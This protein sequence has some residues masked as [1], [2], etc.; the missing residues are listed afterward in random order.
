M[1]FNSLVFLLFFAVV[2]GCAVILRPRAQNL[3][4]LAASYFFYG[5][6]DWRFLGLLGVSTTL[7]FLCGLRIHSA[8]GRARQVWLGVSLAGNL[9]LLFFF[10]YFN[11]FADSAA[12]ALRAFGMEPGWTTLHIVLPVGISFYTFQTLSY[13]IDI[14]RG[15]LT[16]TRSPVIFALYVAFFPQ[17]VA[18]PIERAAHLL[19]Q[20]ANPRRPT[21]TQLRDGFW[22]ILHGYLLKVVLSDNLAPFVDE[23]FTAPGEAHG[24]QIPAAVLAFAFQ[25]YGDF[26]GYSNIARG[27]SF[28]L[29]VDL[30][31]NFRQPYFATNPSDFW[32]RWHIS[33]STWLRD[34]LYIPLGGNRAGARRTQVNLLLT[35]VLG[36]LW[37]GAAWNFVAWGLYHGLLL[38]AYHALAPWAAR[39]LPGAWRGQLLGAALFFPFTLFGWLLFRVENLG[40]VVTLMGNTVQ[41]FT[42]NGKLSLLTL[43]G[44]ALPVLA[45]DLWQEAKGDDRAVARLPG[46]VRGTLYLL[47][48]ALIILCGARG[49]HVFI[50]FQF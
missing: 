8:Q 50:Y 13:T 32:R 30:M 23:V 35:M 4:L 40:D 42:W 34:Y 46:P 2:F 12:A 39:A 41:P 43:A 28:W 7:D 25:I 18:G 5:Y 14:Y 45:V 29:G 33:L 26:A 36:G 15:R 49:G 20:L 3:F 1:V 17:L 47:W 10:K 48:F 21:Y 44:F 38:V 27:I 19:P 6:W 31:V 24:L 22:L 16:P 9:G 37:H 11:F